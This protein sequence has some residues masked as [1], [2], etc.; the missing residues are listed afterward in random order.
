MSKQLTKSQI[1]YRAKFKDPR[2]QK[3]RLKIMELDN[4]ECQRCDESDRTLNVH[5][6]YYEYGKSPWDYPDLA[7][8]TLCEE[9]HEAETSDIKEAS[10]LI[11]KAIRSRFFSHD[12]VRMAESLMGLDFQYRSRAIASTACQLFGN[13]VLQKE[14]V[15]IHIRTELAIEKEIDALFGID[16]TKE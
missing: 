1:E 4:F 16:N 7:L 10:D 9:C 15:A 5:H 14:H 12:M 8:V 2:W 6:R 11:I 13:P 3:K